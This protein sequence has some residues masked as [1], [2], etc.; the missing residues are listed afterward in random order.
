MTLIYQLFFF[1]VD[2]SITIALC[3]LFLCFPQIISCQNNVCIIND[4][5]NTL[6]T[7][8]FF[9]FRNM[10]SLYCCLFPKFSINYRSVRNNSVK[11]VDHVSERVR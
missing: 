6:I 7:L 1:P 8:T 9:A 3:L 11:K 2:S 10:G 5:R 4:K